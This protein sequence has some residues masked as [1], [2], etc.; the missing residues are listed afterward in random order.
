MRKRFLQRGT[1]SYRREARQATAAPGTAVLRWLLLACAGVVGAYVAWSSGR[2]VEPAPA[3]AE[4]IL[5]PGGQ[6]EREREKRAGEALLAADEALAKFPPA[7]EPAPE[8][9]RALAALDAVLAEPDAAALSPVRQ[10][11]HARIDRALAQMRRTVPASGATVWQIYNHGFVVRTATATICFDLVRAKYLRDF[12]L[13]ETAMQRV[14]TE[15]DALFVSHVHADHAESFVA[16]TFVDQGKPVVAPAQIGY[17]DP[18]YDKVH[19]LEASLSKVHTLPIRGG[20]A[21]LQVVIFPGHQ[22]AEIDNNVVLV[23]TPDGIS[24]AHTGDQWNAADFSWIDRVAQRHRVDILLPNDWT[25]NIARVARGFGP[26]V[27]IPGHANELGHDP[28]KRQPYTF[29]FERRAGATSRFGSQPREG[30]A[31]PLVVMAWGEA[32]HY[33]RRPGAGR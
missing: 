28:A 8:R 22:D 14:V 1:M 24:V 19:H 21:R 11:F 32:Y 3:M 13:P 27:V 30:Y 31:Q 7:T 23:T 12:A 6:D 29:S 9:L 2:M 18:L 26:A 33:E 10:F 15:C 25:Y 5:R 20:R 17:R 16:Q 4:S